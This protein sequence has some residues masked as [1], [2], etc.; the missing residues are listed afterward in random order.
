M[1]KTGHKSCRSIT[2]KELRLMKNERLTKMLENAQIKLVKAHKSLERLNKQLIKEQAEENSYTRW[3]EDD[4]QRKEREIK[5]INFS[6][7]EYSAKL[8]A[9][10]NIE[11]IP[12]LRKFIDNW[13]VLATEY[14]TEQY[15]KLIKYK[16]WLEEQEKILKQWE[17]E[18]GHIYY[19]SK[20][21]EEKRKELKIDSKTKGEYLHNHFDALILHIGMYE[22]DWEQLIQ[23]E[24][25]REAERK[26]INFLNRIKKA[27]GKTL[28]CSGLYIA[29]NLEING[30]V[31][32]ELGKVKVE[33]ITAGGHNIQCYHY[34]VLIKDISL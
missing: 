29:N 5:D 24:V 21:N 20:E 26:Y 1:H 31:A 30:I 32:G 8:K 25:N 14:Y 16:K 11:E 7:N 34:R 2:G 23:K 4:I 28:D 3:I 6:I 9:V 13:K 19:R 15:N 17:K 12:V 27:V 33:T 18:T 22:L 10:Q